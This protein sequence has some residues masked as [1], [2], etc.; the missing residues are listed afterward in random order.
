MNKKELLISKNKKFN[1]IYIFAHGAGAPMDNDWMEQVSSKLAEQ[2]VKV[3]RFEFPYMA[4][5]RLT[6]KKRPPNPAKV[7]LDA[8]REVFTLVDKSKPVFIGGKSMG[9][10]MATL[11]ADELSPN[12]VICLGFPFHAPGKDAGSRIDHLK[13]MNTPTLIVQGMR[14][15][16]GTFDDVKGYK[17]SSNIK[18]EWL[19]DGDHS[20][21]PRVKSGHTLEE[22]LD[23]AVSAM[24]D[25]MNKSK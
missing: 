8:W 10:R 5:R 19:E 16:M 1:S 20:L 3:V 2:G 4:E 11:V 21:K 13:E 24:I 14:D 6:G 22:H 23:R 15:S 25:F 18:I 7:L 17:L 9:G 12:G